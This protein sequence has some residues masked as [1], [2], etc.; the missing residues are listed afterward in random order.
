MGEIY[1]DR[2][3][4]YNSQIQCAHHWLIESSNDP[5]SFGMCKHCGE[6]REFFNDWK[7]LCINS[8]HASGDDNAQRHI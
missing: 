2:I 4:R 5:T 7:T 8:N 3:E 1:L 6:I